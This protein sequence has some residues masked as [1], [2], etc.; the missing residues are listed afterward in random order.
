MPIRFPTTSSKR[1]RARLAGVAAAVFVAEAIWVLA[2]IGLGIRLQAPV[3]T[4]YP[5]PMDIGPLTV[6]VTVV[7]LSLIGWALLA[8]LE[9]LTAG[10]HRVWLAVAVV[11]LAASLVMPL[12]GTG[13]SAADRAMLVL[14][15]LTVALVVIPVL[16]R[17]APRRSAPSAQFPSTVARGRVA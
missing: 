16:Y 15:H 8:G 6:A 5:E 13:V 3:G 17:T 7:V 2:S 9:R 4:G 11:A 12:S 14:M 10:A 1:N